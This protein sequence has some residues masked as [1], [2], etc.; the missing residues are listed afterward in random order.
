MLT[1]TSLEF[2][3]VQVAPALAAQLPCESGPEPAS[4]G[5]AIRTAFE[6]LMGFVLQRNLAM[7]GQPRVIY[8]AYGAK[9]VAFTV[10]LPVTAGPE[11]A[12]EDS[13]IRVEVLPAG[14]CLRFTH[15]GPY[16]ELAQTY[17]Q[18]TEF[19]KDKGW[20]QSEAD[21]VRYMPMWEELSE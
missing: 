4:I 9:G 7:N 20:M 13:S 5:A 21:W 16:S 14:K 11:S 2:A 17:N 19:M 8:T 18:I 10:A 6:S 3:E 15:R 1:A 12:M